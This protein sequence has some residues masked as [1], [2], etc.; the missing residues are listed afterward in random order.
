MKGTIYMIKN[1]ENNCC[2][3]GATISKN[4]KKRYYRHREIRNDWERYTDL[5][6]CKDNKP[7]F[8]I[9]N[10]KLYPNRTELRKLENLYIQSYQ[11]H[12]T[13]KITNRNL[14]YISTELKKDNEKKYQLKYNNSEKGKF[15]RKWGTY[16]KKMRRKLLIELKSI[17]F[18]NESLGLKEIGKET[19]GLCPALL[20]IASS[21]KEE[22]DTHL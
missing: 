5:F 15:M 6:N 7:D 4:P 17:I 11:N 20:T 22:S 1:C 10:Q 21:Q 2:Y 9:L 8:I 3:I 19:K 13:L 18:L 14:A 12:P 16:R